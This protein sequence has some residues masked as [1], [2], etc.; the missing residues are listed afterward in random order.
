[1]SGHTGQ[2]WNTLFTGM[3]QAMIGIAIGL[4]GC[5]TCVP[6]GV[7]LMVVLQVVLPS[8]D[9]S[10]N[11]F[12]N[13]PSGTCRTTCDICNIPEPPAMLIALLIF[14]LFGDNGPEAMFAIPDL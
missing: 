3:P 14:M 12:T 5:G 1:M 9:P 8:I 10:S 6:A 7:R 2:R 11:S 4:H 13:R